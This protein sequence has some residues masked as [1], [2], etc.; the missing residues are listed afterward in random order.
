MYANFN[1]LFKLNKKW[2]LDGGFNDIEHKIDAKG[3]F[4]DNLEDEIN[5]EGKI[6]CCSANVSDMD[7]CGFQTE[8]FE[9][10]EV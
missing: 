5:A 9:H 7:S 8:W 2:N 6:T 3:R 4:C 1:G 10:A